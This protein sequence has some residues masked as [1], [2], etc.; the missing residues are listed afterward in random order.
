MSGNMES[1]E[2]IKAEQQPQADFSQAFSSA[3]QQEVIKR[4]TQESKHEVAGLN[5]E[6]N[7]EHSH[8][9]KRIEHPHAWYNDHDKPTYG[10]PSEAVITGGV[11][12]I[13][14]SGW[15]NLEKR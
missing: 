7:H 11:K 8:L 1:N 13:L 2:R 4:L 15:R 14:Q 10:L 3:D 9:R 6:S 12:H 5:I